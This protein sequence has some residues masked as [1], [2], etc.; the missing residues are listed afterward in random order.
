[1]TTN[2]REQREAVRKTDTNKQSRERQK[3]RVNVCRECRGHVG[4]A[5]AAK[6]QTDKNSAPLFQ[7]WTQSTDRCSSAKSEPV[8]LICL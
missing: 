5:A 4:A 2:K 8:C 6:P 7:R 1:M 3:E